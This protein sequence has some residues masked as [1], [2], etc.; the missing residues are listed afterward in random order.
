ML[1]N[2]PTLLATATGSLLLVEVP[3]TLLY[4]TKEFHRSA[5]YG[6][7]GYRPRLTTRALRNL[8]FIAWCAGR[9]F[10]PEGHR[11]IGTLHSDTP[12]DERTGL[13]PEEGHN[14]FASPTT[15]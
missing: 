13:P 8:A 9:D 6:V 3:N 11:T 14:A 15:C 10:F 5:C 7:L 4:N 12:S 1:S 2:L